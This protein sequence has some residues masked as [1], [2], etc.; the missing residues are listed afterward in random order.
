MRNRVTRATAEIVKGS[1]GPRVYAPVNPSRIMKANHMLSLLIAVVGAI[2]VPAAFQ[3]VQ[4]SPDNNM[5]QYPGS[6][7]MAGITRG[8]AVIAVSI[9]AEGKLRDALPLAYTQP[10]LARTSLAAVREW[11][12]IPAAL[13]GARVPVQTEI[14]FDYTVHGAVI[15]TNAMNHFFFD[16]FENVGDT[17]WAYRPGRPDRLDAPL[18]RVAGNAPK[19]AHEALRAGITGTVQ[20]HFYVDETGEVRMP[21][22]A[23]VTNP[24]LMEQAMAAVRGWKFTPPTI[25]GN[26]VLIAAS[27]DFHFGSK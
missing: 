26:P 25:R 17:A 2:P 6:L 9:D 5:P 21:A 20:V 19:Y 1:G 8:Y 11:S 27:Q 15:T 18:V 23:E 7:L 12:F 24:Y 16:S 22:V 4:V 14:R 10:E 3:S 13:D